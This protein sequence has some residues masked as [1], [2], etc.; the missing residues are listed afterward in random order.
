MIESIDHVNLVVED[1]DRIAHFYQ[2]LLGM[3]VTKRVTIS[4]PWIDHTVGLKNV[5]G[6]V[7]YLDPPSGPRV[8]LI[9][10]R[11][12]TGVRPPGLG[13]SNTPGLRHLAFRVEGI[14][15]LVAK[16]RASG[17]QF[18]SAVQQVPTKQVSYGDAQKHIVYLHDPEGNLIELCEYK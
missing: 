13:Q 10:Y 11:S 16:L 6:D 4:G 18:F 2:D 12:P 5:V 8:E 17:I 3:K 9:C 15:Q 7:I 14:E 1:L